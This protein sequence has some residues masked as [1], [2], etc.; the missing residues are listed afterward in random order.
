MSRFSGSF[1][2]FAWQCFLVFCALAV[3]ALP[4]YAGNPPGSYTSHCQKINVDTSSPYP[5]RWTLT[6]TCKKNSSSVP[7]LAKLI[8]YASCI[9]AHNDIQYVNGQLQ[10][11]LPPGTYLDSCPAKGDRMTAAGGAAPGGN[12]LVAKCRV[13]N[14]EEE[15]LKFGTADQCPAPGIMILPVFNHPEIHQLVCHSPD[16]SYEQSCNNIRFRDPLNLFNGASVL[17][18]NCTERDGAQTLAAFAQPRIT[19]CFAGDIANINGVLTCNVPQNG[20]VAFFGSCIPSVNRGVQVPPPTSY[21][22]GCPGN[23]DNSCP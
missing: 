21:T 23:V 11:A 18:A 7:V 5:F 20:C 17:W 12:V 15:I 22:E 14:G 4:A 8:G 13:G 16:G 10:C 1:P 2:R 9:W 6:A 3:F 19:D